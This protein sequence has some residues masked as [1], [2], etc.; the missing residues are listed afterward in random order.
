MVL[1][2]YEYAKQLDDT[3]E[4][5]K[6]ED[7]TNLEISQLDDYDTFINHGIGNAALHGYK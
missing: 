4:N 3:K 5:T 7:Y 1:R 6:W 2:N